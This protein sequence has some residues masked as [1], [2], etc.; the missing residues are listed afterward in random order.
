MNF[1]DMLKQQIQQTSN[2]NEKVDYPSNHLKAKELRFDKDTSTLLVRIL[3]PANSSDFFAVPAREIWL[4]ARNRNG[5]DLNF[6]A[7]L[8]DVMDPQTSTLAANLINWQ[9]QERVPNNFNRKA[10][11][12]RVYYVN[13]I[14]LLVDQAG[15][16][17]HEVGQDGQPVVRLMKLKQSAY[18]EILNKLADPFMKPAASDDYS[19]I[20]AVD[21]YPIKITKPAKGSQQMSYSVDVYQRSLGAL[22]QNWTSLLEDLKYQATPSEEYNKEYTEYFISVVNGVEGQSAGAPVT[23]AQA[24]AQQ[25]FTQ[26]PP[27]QFQATQQQPAAQYGA[28][29]QQFAQPA[30]AQQPAPTQQPGFDPQAVAAG[31]DTMLSSAPDPFLDNAVPT[32]QPVEVPFDTG[33]AAEPTQPAPQTTSAGLPDVNDLLANMKGALQ[34]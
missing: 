5:K 20:S 23:P 7:V 28:P 10:F 33:A 1:Q 27:T 2:N 29:V 9:A 19:F 34:Q 21:A 14:Q 22:P 15:N 26:A 4:N 16:I 24:P 30:P 11:P 18:T 12:S 32:Q 8:P 6:S 25:Q 31:M 3:P 17:Q 13:V